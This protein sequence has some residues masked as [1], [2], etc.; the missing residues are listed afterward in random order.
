MKGDVMKPYYS[1]EEL[2]RILHDP[3]YKVADGLVAC[4]VVPI[5]D[6]KPADLSQWS[7][8]GPLL[9][10]ENEITIIEGQCPVPDPSR[11]MVASEV[12][13]QSWKECISVDEQ[14]KLAPSKQ[15]PDF[16][17]A[18]TTYPPEL[19]IAVQAWKAISTTEGKGKPK[20][21]IEAWLNTNADQ[22]SN[23]AKKRIEIV[24]NWEKTGGA[25]RTN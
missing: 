24:A 16:D 15:Q 5:Y 25:T 20:A 19:D 1:I 3:I 22:L 8:L 4:E 10:G 12:L 21:R 13:P 11:V 18:S 6:G 9:T 14:K 23:A 2:A 17:K 7:D